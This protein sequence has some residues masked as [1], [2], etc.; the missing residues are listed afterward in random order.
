MA[1]DAALPRTPEAPFS[2]ATREGA[3][4]DAP[5]P[6]PALEFD[7]PTAPPIEAV[8]FAGIV[9]AS[10]LG[11]A[12]L[13]LS[14][15]RLAFGP[16]S[17]GFS[18]V[19]RLRLYDPALRAAGSLETFVGQRRNRDLCVTANFRHDWLGL[20]SDKVAALGYLAAHGLPTI[21][22]RA[23]DAP[24]LSGGSGRVL[25]DRRTLEAFLL[26][27]GRYPLFGKRVE[28]VQSLGAI[29]LARCCPDTRMLDGVV[30]PV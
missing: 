9:R 13:A 30:D 11:P 17:L 25:T 12:A 18:D 10:G 1:T 2:S 3:V 16:G 14:F 26:D 15:A 27:P 24:R 8:T 21:P 19:V 28:E 22:V 7:R 20:M 23:I 4:A 6:R 5:V 29:A